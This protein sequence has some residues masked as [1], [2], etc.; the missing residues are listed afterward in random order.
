MGFAYSAP[1]S[2]Y[3]P[4]LGDLFSRL[5][6]GTLMGFLTLGHGIIGGI[7]PYLWGWIADT[8]GGY[9]LNCPISAACYVVVALALV[10]LK[11]PGKI[12]R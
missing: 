4:F 5:I 8:T 12:E 3:T 7:G 11:V 6:V 2:L 1:F 9:L 10:F